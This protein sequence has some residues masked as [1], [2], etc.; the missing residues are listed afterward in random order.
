MIF[1]IE[2]MYKKYF[3]EEKKEE[4]YDYYLEVVKK[5]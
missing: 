4:I 3:V 1:G 5:Y 2:E